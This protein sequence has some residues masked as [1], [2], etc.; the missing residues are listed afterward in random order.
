[1]ARSARRSRGFMCVPEFTVGPSITGTA[2]VGQELTGASGTISRGTV[3]SRQWLRDGVDI[4]GATGATYV[5]QEADVGA[6]ITFAVTA[7]GNLLATNTT[8]AVSA[9]TEAVSA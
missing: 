1:M 8:V 9:A 7:V 5:V 2:Q 4:D 6:V 3:A